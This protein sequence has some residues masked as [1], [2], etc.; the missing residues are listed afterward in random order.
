MQHFNP[1]IISFPGNAKGAHVSSTCLFIIDV[2]LATTPLFICWQVNGSA[3]DLS[4]PNLDMHIRSSLPSLFLSA[5]AWNLKQ[6]KVLKGEQDCVV[7]SHLQSVLFA[8]P[9][10]LIVTPSPKIAEIPRALFLPSLQI[11]YLY[12]HFLDCLSSHTAQ[13]LEHNL[14]EQTTELGDL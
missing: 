10:M 12:K 11:S 6:K 7:L 14:T 4:V 5:S 9:A 3:M 8:I 1:S 2:V 13:E